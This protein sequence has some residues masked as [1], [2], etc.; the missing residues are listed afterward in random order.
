VR[1]SHD[2]REQ[3]VARLRDGYVAGRI[4]T[5]TFVHRIDDAMQSASHDQLRGLTADLP[6]QSPTRLAR[7]RALLRRRGLGLPEAGGLLEAHL[8]IGRSSACQLVLADDTVSRRHAELRIESGCWLLRDLG[9][10]NGTWV[11]GRRV[12]EAEVRPG[13]L[14]HLGGAAIRL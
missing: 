6:A 7:L 5:D 13:D 9:S 12:V 1:P 8:V 2:T 3:T 14:I 11:N 4:G 10:S